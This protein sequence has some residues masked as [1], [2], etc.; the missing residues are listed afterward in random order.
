MYNCAA[1][2]GSSYGSGA[3]RQSSAAEPGTQLIESKLEDSNAGAS[4]RLAVRFSAHALVWIRAA[5][6]VLILISAAT[7]ILDIARFATRVTASP[8]LVAPN[9]LWS[10][11]ATEAAISELGLT[12]DR[13]AWFNAVLGWLSATAYC[14]VGII[15]FSRRKKSWLGVYVALMFGVLG[16]SGGLAGDIPAEAGSLLAAWKEVTSLLGWQFL[17]VFFYFFPDGKFVPQWTRWLIGGWVAFN[18]LWLAAPVLRG[19]L[20]FFIFP[21]VLSTMASQIYRY[22]RYSDEL[23]R[24]QTKWI[25]YMVGILILTFSMAFISFYWLSPPTDTPARDFLLASAVQLLMNLWLL[26]FPVTVAIAILRYRLWDIDIIIRRTLI[27]VPLTAILAGVFSASTRLTQTLL[28]SPSGQQSIAASTLTTLIIVAAFDPLKRW[29][30]RLVDDILNEGHD[31]RARWEAYGK[32]VQAFLEMTDP[33]ASARRFLD[34]AMAAFEATGAAIYLGESDQ[35]QLVEQRGEPSQSWA[36]TIP[37]IADGRQSGSLNLGRR[38]GGRIYSPD[39]RQAL[40][41]TANAVAKSL[42]IA[43]VQTRRLRG[44]STT[45]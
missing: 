18:L 12:P 40:T 7:I 14:A 34:E 10:P 13:V 26:L 27:Y 6:F 19:A 9:D 38:S 1:Q 32:E 33:E 4:Q 22:A 35:Q 37:L 28:L 17:L 31:P 2:V 36:L 20:S 24:Q 23:Q 11:E 5:V 16:T 29:L 45:G 3:P 8:G 44:S 41:T 21:L 39:D 25:V 15:V 30:S 43:L 42:S